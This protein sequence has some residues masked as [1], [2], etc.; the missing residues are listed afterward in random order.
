MMQFRASQV[1]TVGCT[2]AFL[3]NIIQSYLD[4]KDN[5]EDTISH[6]SLA[7][8]VFPVMIKVRVS[9]GYNSTALLEAGYTSTEGYFAG[10][11]RHH[12]A[13]FGWAGHTAEGGV[14]A[15][16]DQ[17][18]DRVRQPNTLSDVLEGMTIIT[19]NRMERTFSPE[20]VSGKLVKSYPDNFFYVNTSDLLS[21]FPGDTLNSVS[22]TF[23]KIPGMSVS[24][25]LEGTE[26]I[27][28]RPLAMNRYI[29]CNI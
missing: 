24:V 11:S 14:Q 28:K 16:V 3:V 9:P 29:C 22:L 4:M 26:I 5:M 6:Y 10:Q 25:Q 8:M 23:K 20:N 12:P 21:E 27:V 2:I 17:V 15:T 13:H 19:S 1:V 18:F 7:S